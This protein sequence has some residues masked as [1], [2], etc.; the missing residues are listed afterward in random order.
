MASAHGKGE[1][2]DI[3]LSPRATRGGTVWRRVGWPM[4]CG[5]HRRDA[6]PWLPEGD[7]VLLKHSTACPR[8]NVSSAYTGRLGEARPCHP[9][10]MDT[11]A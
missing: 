10:I 6:R 2:V 5:K 3:R 7:V 9:Q 4:I 8:Q 1:G 11:P